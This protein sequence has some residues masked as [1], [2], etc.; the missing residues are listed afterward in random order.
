MMD[1]IGNILAIV[2]GLVVLLDRFSAR[3]TPVELEKRITEIY[4]DMNELYPS[5]SAFEDVKE[6]I[7]KIYDIII[8]KAEL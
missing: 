8:K 6:K 1:N 4:K 2:M 7:D 3:V 5:K